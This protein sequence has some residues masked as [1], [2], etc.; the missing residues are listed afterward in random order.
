MSN[1][2]QGP[3]LVDVAKLMD[4]PEIIVSTLV[5]LCVI[6]SSFGPIP[7]PTHPPNLLRFVGGKVLY[8]GELDASGKTGDGLDVSSDSGKVRRALAR[9]RGGIGRG[10]LNIRFLDGRVA[11]NDFFTDRKSTRLNSSHLGISYAV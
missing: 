5:R 3:M 10:C 6:D 11:G 4:A 2:E 9:E 7:H 8:D 1:A